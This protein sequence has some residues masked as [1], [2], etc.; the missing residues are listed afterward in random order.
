MSW[1]DTVRNASLPKKSCAKSI[2]P[3]GVRGRFARS[4]VETRNIA[5]APSASDAVMIGVWTQKKPCSW[6]KRWIAMRERVAHA[7]HGADHVGARPQVRD[8][9]QELHRVRLG[10]D[11]IGVRVVDP[12]DDL[13]RASPAS[14]TAGP[15]PAT[16]RCCRSPR[17]R[18]RR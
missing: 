15:C 14:R 1:P 5:P 4:S 11:R 10:L 17:P 6:K 3:S 9:A 12:A 2:L 8:L 7:R 16:A 13:D 18:S